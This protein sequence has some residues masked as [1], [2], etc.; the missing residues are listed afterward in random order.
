MLHSVRSIRVLAYTQS[1]IVQ[2]LI[3]HASLITYDEVCGW[4][5][6]PRLTSP[7]SAPD[8]SEPLQRSAN[9]LTAENLPV[10]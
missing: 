5:I 1:T 4:G 3:E 9:V 6:G 10:S 7:S 8:R 2:P